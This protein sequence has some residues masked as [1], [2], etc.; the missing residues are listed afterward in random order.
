VTLFGK[1]LT[2]TAAIGIFIVVSL[3]LLSLFAPAI[4]PFSEAQM[5]GRP[6]GAPSVEH[7]L[8]LDN[9]GRD[10]FSRLLYG[11]RT[12]IGI[13]AAITALAFVVG[14]TL[15]LIA[16]I[17][18]KWL[19]ELLS[20]LADLMLAVPTL[21]A[22]FVV[23]SVLGTGLDVLIVTVAILDSPKVYRLARSAGLGVAPLEFVETARQRGEG[24]A[25]IV[26]R[27][28]LPNVLAPLIAEFGLRFC[29]A[30]LFVA[31]LSFLGLGIQPPNAD[32]G[33]MVRDYSLMINM[34]S[35]APLL[36]AGAI[37]LL[38]VGVNFIVDWVLDEGPRKLVEV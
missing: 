23:L 11:G 22:A 21:I 37:A 26:N 9:L 20:R 18:P 12:S 25:W 36:P 6:W 30:F 15:G 14:V 10:I 17:A 34:G 1:R 5:I 27:E 38:T 4:A 24:T 28:I 31:A 2:V 32:W 3:G 13:A 19:D 16:C 33:S 8:G 29:Y 35:V 7:I